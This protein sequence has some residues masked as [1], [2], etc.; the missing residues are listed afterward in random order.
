MA[1]SATV[2]AVLT[3]VR[4]LPYAVLLPFSL[5]LALL[6][7]SELAFVIKGATFLVSAATVNDPDSFGS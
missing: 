2:V 5:V 4:L 6:R 7:A 1:G 3:L